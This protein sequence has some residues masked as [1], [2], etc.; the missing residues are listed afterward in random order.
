MLDIVYFDWVTNYELSKLGRIQY[1]NIGAGIYRVH[2][3]GVFSLSDE[4]TKNRLTFETSEIIKKD[5]E[6]FIN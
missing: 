5:Y 6:R 2:K 3:N 1:L 4:E